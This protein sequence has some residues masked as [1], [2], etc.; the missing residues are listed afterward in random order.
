MTERLRSLQLLIR[1]E[2]AADGGKTTPY[3]RGTGARRVRPARR[4]RAAGDYS[5]FIKLTGPADK[6]RVDFDRLDDKVSLAFKMD[7][8]TIASLSRLDGTLGNCLLHPRFWVLC[9]GGGCKAGTAVDVNPP[10]TQHSWEF[11]VSELLA[12]TTGEAGEHTYTWGAGAYITTDNHA[13]PPC[14]SIAMTIAQRDFTLVKSRPRRPRARPTSRSPS[15]STTRSSGRRK[16][17]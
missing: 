13:S 7:I 1:R 16:S 12:M 11:R 9:K 5:T 2:E 14:P 4:L 8:D 15:T 3:D 6:A 17:S 10:D